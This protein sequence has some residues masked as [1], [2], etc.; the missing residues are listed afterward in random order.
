[1]AVS[2]RGLSALT[3][4]LATAALPSA[5]PALAISGAWNR[6]L[7]VHSGGILTEFLPAPATVAPQATRDEVQR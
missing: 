3:L 5:A 2:A 6:R 7:G 4:A 1:M